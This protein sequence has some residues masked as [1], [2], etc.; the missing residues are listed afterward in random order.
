VRKVKD[1]H[2]NARSAKVK[3]SLCC[4]LIVALGSASQ[5]SAQGTTKNAAGT[6]VAVIDI[7]RVFKEHPRFKSQMEAMKT[8]VKQFEG[9]LQQRGQEIQKVQTELREFEPSSAEYKQR[10]GQILKIQADGQIAAAQKK[11]EFLGQEAKIYFNVYK[12]IVAEV[13]EFAAQNGIAIVVRFNSEPIDSDDRQSVLEGVNRAVV[14]QS[15]SNITTAILERL[16]RKNPVAP[17]NAALPQ[18]GQAATR[19]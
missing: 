1:D 13:A 2:H 3:T 8:Q 5:L 10:E 16:I 14:Y 18:Q 4:A 6:R 9:Q 7:S 11:K 17:Q 19:R 12:E 15:K